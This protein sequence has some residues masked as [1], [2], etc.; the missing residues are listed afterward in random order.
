MTDFDTVRTETWMLSL[1][2]DWTEKGQTES[3]ALYFES[4]DGSKAMYITTWELGGNDHR[5]ATEVAAAFAHTD[6]SSLNDMEGYKWRVMS[7]TRSAS[8]GVSEVLV[9]SLAEQKDYRIVGRILARPPIVVRA[10]F[11]DY[12]CK[13]YEE[14]AT[15]FEEIIRSLCF[16]EP[17]A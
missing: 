4:P 10:S 2:V 13:H 17:A 12:L 9:D 5:S 11:H 7:E 14:S 8:E 16:Y 15:Y 6:K 1:P 3:G